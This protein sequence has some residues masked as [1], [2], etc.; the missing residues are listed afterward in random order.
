MPD[1]GTFVVEEGCLLFENQ[2][3]NTKYQV[4]TAAGPVREVDSLGRLLLPLYNVVVGDGTLYRVAGQLAEPDEVVLPQPGDCDQ[5]MLVVWQ[6]SLHE[7][8]EP[9][10]TAHVAI[11]EC[12]EGIADSEADCIPTLVTRGS[13]WEA[14]RSLIAPDVIDELANDIDGLEPGWSVWSTADRD[15]IVA[16]G[17][18]GDIV[19]VN[20]PG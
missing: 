4:A 5:P 17:P 16:L 11:R 12:A 6:T 20:P 15:V 8:Q 13:I 7:D 18:T 1:F 2:R 14:D 3:D 9:V 10:G 19:F